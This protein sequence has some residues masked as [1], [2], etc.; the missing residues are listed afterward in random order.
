MAFNQQPLKLV[1][2]KKAIHVFEIV[3]E[4]F[5]PETVASFGEEWKKF[6]T[7]SEAEISHIGDNYFDI[8]PDSLL[9][10]KRVLD[11]GCGTGR[12]T[13]YVARKAAFV[14]AID[15]SEAVYSAAALLQEVDNTRVSRAS[16]DNIPFADNS[17]DFVF[18]LGVLH[19][20]PDTKD[21][22]EKCIRKLKPGGFFL[23]Y[24][25]YSL[26]N[27]GPFFKWLFHISNV[28]RKVISV[29]PAQLKKFVCDLMAVIFYLPF[30]SCA[31]L[32][33]AIGLK[34]LATKIPLAWYADKSWKVIRNDS[35]DRFGTPLEKR[36]SK[37]E[38]EQMMFDCGLSNIKFSNIE[39]YWHALGQKI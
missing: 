11:M 36:F 16:V 19:H 23:V 22:M 27:R 6:D 7:F 21:A 20:I 28:L 30:I 8:V 24:L 25:Y 39:P 35:L 3:Q 29:L 4:N 10:G 31:K 38:I 1:G 32:F 9:A 18:S 17:F 33:K 14:E 12:W 15:P 26:D 5:D 37:K 2:S 34:K 13:K